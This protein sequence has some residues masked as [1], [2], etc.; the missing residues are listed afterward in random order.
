M[1]PGISKLTLT[2]VSKSECESDSAKAFTAALLVLYEGLPGGCVIPDTRIQLALQ[3]F[4][5]Y[6]IIIPCLLPVERNQFLKFNNLGLIA[7]S[8]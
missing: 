3:I 6:Q 5:K 4:S 1:Y 2:C 7:A 8:G